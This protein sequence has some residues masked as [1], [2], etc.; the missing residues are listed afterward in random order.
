MYPL[1]VLEKTGYRNITGNPVVILDERGKPFYDTRNLD[2]RVWEFNLPAGNYI[3]A[4]GKISQRV[5]PVVF[6]KMPLPPPERCKRGN[7]EHFEIV[8]AENPHKCTVDWLRRRITYDNSFKD[9][10][11]PVMVSIYF[12][13]CG[14]RYYKT[15]EH[16]DAYAYNQMIEC[17]Y[18]P[19]QIGNSFN[20][21]LSDRADGR[22]IALVEKMVDAGT[23]HF[24]KRGDSV[25]KRVLVFQNH[26]EKEGIEGDHIEKSAVEKFF[27]GDRK[28]TV[29]SKPTTVWDTAGGKVALR[30]VPAWDTIGKVESLNTAGTWG[31][32]RKD[33]YNPK[34]GAIFLQDSMST[35]LLNVE[36][37]KSV[38]DA[39][40][41][42][43]EKV[44]SVV[45]ENVFD[46]IKSFGIV[47]I[48]IIAIALYF[49]LTVLLPA[50]KTATA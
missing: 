10:E 50:M 13:E 17:G 45:G 21:V 2:R 14:H 39:V 22:K 20:D 5:S 35:V 27:I 18:N 41:R 36:A 11:L 9:E 38:G 26:F 29:N 34:G 42:E 6:G 31:Y 49:F 12:H 16:C 15:E 37:P 25:F 30:T 24:Q 7:P 1:K 8:F 3:V 19:S 40:G 23:N 47:K 46:F 4:A 32:L 28:F 43:A 33:Q 48:L 44:V